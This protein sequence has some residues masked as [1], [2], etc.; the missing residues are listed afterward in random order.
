MAGRTGTSSADLPAPRLARGITVFA[1]FCFCLIAFN[2]VLRD[3]FGGRKALVALACAAAVF[4]IQ[5]LNSSSKARR[6]PM[7]R[8]IVMLLWQAAFTVGP[9]L[10]FGAD[11]GGMLGCLAGSCLLLLPRRLGWTLYAVCCLSAFAEAWITGVAPL[12]TVYVLQSTMLT[13][14]VI[15]GLTRLADLVEE[16]FSSRE[17]RARAAVLQERLRFARDLHDL[18][19]YS[20]SSITLKTELVNRLVTSRPDRARE[21]IAGVLDISRQALADVR[22]VASGYRE[23]SLAAEVDS[24]ASTLKSAD[25]KAEVEVTCSRMHPVVDTVLAT[26]LREGVTNILRH[27]RVQHCEIRAHSDEETV[28]LRLVN[29]GVAKT[30]QPPAP[31]SGS[32]IGN[33]ETRLAAIGGRVEAGVREDGRFHLLVEAPLKP[34]VPATATPNDVP[35]AVA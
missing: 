18:L 25:V 22:L 3:S 6:W 2:N 12:L 17:E 15:Y 13:G 8:R 26:A 21:E 29:D 7:R 5:L 33:L 4:S 32:G 30:V 9:M 10:L 34:Q 11:W 16:V 27:S 35:Q 19:G 24:V 14:L 28:F 31:W 1:L 20:L 23:M